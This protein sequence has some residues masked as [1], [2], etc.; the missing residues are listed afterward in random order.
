[1]PPME[2]RPRTDI[3][4]VLT[5]VEMPGTMNELMLAA[6]VRE[7]WPLIGIIVVSGRVTIGAAD[8][9]DDGVFFPK[10]YKA[11]ALATAVRAL[12]A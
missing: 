9:P 8:I 11:E 6:S 7:R 1:M 2:C 4:V 5:D 10:P 12:A 3:A